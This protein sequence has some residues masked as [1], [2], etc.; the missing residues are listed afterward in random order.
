MINKFTLKAQE[1]LQRSQDIAA[2]QMHQ[3]VAP[4]HLL[5]AL[6]LQEGSIVP[7]LLDKLGV[8]EQD[9]RAKV[10]AEL[11]NYPKI[12][13]PPANQFYLSRDMGW[14]IE[15]SSQE[16][17]QFKDEF[18]ST[19]HLFLALLE[20]KT[21]AGQI[22]KSLKLN[23]EQIIKI[24]TDL[25]GASTRIADEQPETKYRVL[26]KYG[27]NVTELAK[28]KKLDPVIGRDEEIRRVMQVLARRTKNNPVLIGESGVGKT[29]IVEGLAQRIISGD[30][31][32][33]LIDK[34]IISLDLGAMVAGTR[35]R[36]EFEDR[37]KAVLKEM[38]KA[39]GKFI[40][41]IDELHTLVGA[42]AA[43]GAIDAANMLKP[44]LAKGELHAIGATTLKEYQKYI[45]RD[46]ALE[47]RFQPVYV[48]E[49]SVEDTIAIL[50]GLKEKYELHHGVRITD[51]A[52]LAA[53]KFSSRYL[54]DR[55]LPDKAI[56]LIDEAASALRL[57]ID[58]MPRELDQLRREIMRL[59]IE[60]E[61]LKKE[62]DAASKERLKELEQKLADLKER[63]RGLEIDWRKEKEIIG[64]L[65]ELKNK[66]DAAR[67]EAEMAER[68]VD[69]QKVAEIR[70]GQ[71][72]VFQKLI[73]QEEKK[74]AKIQKK[75][76]F[77]KEEIVEED[78]ARVVSRWSGV[79]VQ[80]MLEEEQE[81]L[82]KME[83]VLKNRLI[84][85]D[86]AVSIV[87]NAIRRSR[88]GVS[89][90]S[91]PIG[92]FIFLGPTGVGKTELAKAL[93]EFMFDSEQ[94]II[95]LDMSEY[96]ERHA[97]A[98]M[99]GSP[100]GYVGYE[101]GGQLTEQIRRRPYSIILFDE[102]EKAH[103]EVF[104][105]LLQIL[106]EGRLTDSKGRAV[107]FKNT[108]I[109]M[110]SNIGSGYLE[111]MAHLGFSVKKEE[112]R[113][114]KEGEIKGKIRRALREYFKPE[115]LNRVDEIVIFN[116]LGEK[117]IEKIVDI[118]LEKVV[119]KLYSDKKVKLE[120]TPQAKK[121]LTER[122]FDPQ[123][124]A[125]PLKRLIQR[126]ILDELAKK[127]ISGRLKEGKKVEVGVKK[128]E[129]TII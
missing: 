122:G 62:K 109:V 28:K 85:Q 82:L 57:D 72:P 43:E 94:A 56:D 101:E 44:A 87:A 104:N 96:M 89:E 20:S 107:N 63:S 114:E 55:F 75:H 117:E 22:L 65:R 93:A 78:I 113:L 121:I 106:D 103:P 112:K 102:I 66:T 111:E 108:I 5:A 15:K 110:T 41:F 86:E 67:Q 40:L 61:A 24:L 23:R 64:Q 60:K 118:Q 9:L 120:I 54:S 95:R 73:V 80:K 11:A 124:G 125:R 35:F 1:A 127:L 37:L 119:K 45:E 29:A 129:I 36:G 13:L 14:V 115:F 16:A 84:G 30:V 68:L 92:S 32:E 59:E 17:G 47:R 8:N 3:E 12:A 4:E 79:P 69:L 48:E 53:V 52:I 19:E 6:I 38:E 76:R 10:F 21:K 31:P 99:I 88:A 51:S 70:Y 25:R 97:A 98:K 77:L 128:N 50:R 126:L 39:A 123:W 116:S 18:I 100:P 71:I 49:P 34:E 42:G 91:R 58:S 26:E 33:S 46:A 27:R 90:E 7:S 2:Q 105:M 74:L 81:K 83:D